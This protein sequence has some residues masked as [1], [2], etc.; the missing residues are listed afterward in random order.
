VELKTSSRI[1]STT[2]QSQLPSPFTLISSLTNQE[3]TST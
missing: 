1:S 3:S 2:V